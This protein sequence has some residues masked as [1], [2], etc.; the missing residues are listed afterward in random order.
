MCASVTAVTSPTDR[1]CPVVGLCNR[2]AHVTK[3]RSPNRRH[4]QEYTSALRAAQ[5][6]P[7]DEYVSAEAAAARRIRSP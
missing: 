7:R 5:D 1:V 2:G 4:G 3:F 6:S